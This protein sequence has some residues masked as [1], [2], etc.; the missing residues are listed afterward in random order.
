MIANSFDSTFP[1]KSIEIIDNC[2]LSEIIFLR[3]QCSTEGQVYS[4]FNSIKMF[5][6]WSN[7]TCIA[8][9]IWVLVRLDLVPIILVM[10]RDWEMI[11]VIWPWATRHY[12]DNFHRD[13]SIVINF[14]LC[15]QPKTHFLLNSP[16]FFIPH[17]RKKSLI[18]Q[19]ERK[20][21]FFILTSNIT[22][23]RV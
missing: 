23:L 10:L 17:A 14:I 5:P 20:I 11:G 15:S 16:I 7:F 4:D 22:I 13:N 9:G 2:F 12:R 6:V 18:C 3:R 19:A 1:A 8:L 21:N